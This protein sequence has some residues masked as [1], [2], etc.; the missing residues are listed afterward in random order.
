M[1]G[2]LGR[3]LGQSTRVNDSG[4]GHCSYD[5]AYIRVQHFLGSPVAS[6]CC[7]T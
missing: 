4:N 3:V 2:V 1:D 6:E 7:I 5:G